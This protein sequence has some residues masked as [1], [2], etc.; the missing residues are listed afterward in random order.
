M[1]FGLIFDA[2]AFLFIFL[3]FIYAYRIYSMVKLSKFMWLVF[4]M[5]YG[6]VLRTMHLMR[7]FG[8]PVPNPT[9]VS[10]L[11]AVFYVLLFMGIVAIYEP[12]KKMW[13]SANQHP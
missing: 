10:R 13:N 11:F 3:S 1:T 12:I 7:N 4:A 8:V 6:T 2:I 5:A 9:A